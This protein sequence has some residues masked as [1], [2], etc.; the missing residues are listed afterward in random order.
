MKKMTSK[1]AWDYVQSRQTR[2][3]FGLDSLDIRYVFLEGK[4]VI[5]LTYYLE[6][7]KTLVESINENM[8]E[9]QQYST[10]AKSLILQLYCGKDFTLGIEE[11]NELL[12][13]MK[14]LNDGVQFIWEVEN[15]ASTEFR[16]QIC[17]F[18][19]I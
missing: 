18:V 7:G 13:V 14:T 10:K 1:Q 8:L 5:L 16:L 17:I 19:I 2:E 12:T 3:Y 9:I 15:T 6:Q 11:V 4:E